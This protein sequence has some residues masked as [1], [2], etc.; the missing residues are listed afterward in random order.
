MLGHVSSVSVGAG[1][2]WALERVRT[3]FELGALL[4][5]LAPA[6]LLAVVLVSIGRQILVTDTWV[7]LV[8]GREIA[9]HGLPRVE[10]LTVIA[11]GR[12]WVDQQWL[13]QL[14]MYG[15]DRVGGVGLT[16]AIC[17]LAVVAAFA[18]ASRA[19]QE[20]GAAPGA[21][22]A[23]FVV[24]F[25]AGPWGVQTRT[26]AL[27]LPLFS[28]VL[29]L[30]LRDPEA[31]RRSTLW[32]L[33]V[34]CLWANVH[35]SVV[36]GAAMVSLYGLAAL[37]RERSNREAAVLGFL[38]PATVLA[39]PYALELPG[40]YRLMLLHPP[41]GHD[42]VEWQ[43]TTPSA[44]TAVFFGLVALCVV[45]LVVRRRVVPLFHW[46]VLGLTFVAALSAIRLIPWFALTALALLPPLVTRGTARPFRGPA[47]A[48]LA[49]LTIA[50]IVGAA[51]WA[52]SRSYEGPRDARALA[53]VRTEAGSGRVFADLTLADWLLWKIPA[54]RGRVAYDGRPEILTRRQFLG[55]V[56]VARHERGWREALRKYQLLVTLPTK[57]HGPHL[58]GWRRVYAD[59]SLVVLR[60]R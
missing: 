18:F 53:V 20:Q 46:L 21:I 60:R 37:A 10:H 27:A 19:A 3:R 36:L 33:P 35:G 6:A 1:R 40:Y 50:T 43:R 13:A 39:S 26:Q 44:V 58:S 28:V 4:P 15:L 47:A 17:V 30:L 52:T 2:A 22:L 41:Y 25:M 56:A 48:A 57:H 59:D 45:V 42:I 12:D 7:G 14:V 16:V 23:F 38:A 32:A 49:V 24:A 34:L 51:A 5:I 55:V 29:W 54:L 9:R 31:R 11:Q 8:S